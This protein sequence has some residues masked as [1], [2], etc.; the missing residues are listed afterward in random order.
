MPDNE[1]PKRLSKELQG[2]IG[3][4]EKGLEELRKLESK[5]RTTNSV[6]NYTKVGGAVATSVG[7]LGVCAGV[8]AAVCSFITMS[9]VPLIA[10]GSAA[11]VGGTITNVSVEYIRKSRN[12][13][14]IFGFIYF[15][16]SYNFNTIAMLFEILWNVDI[17]DV[18]I[19]FF[20]FLA[21]LL[22]TVNSNEAVP[23]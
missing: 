17:C 22:N 5:V 13:L 21:W 6:C 18:T 11:F 15:L 1:S 23:A 3:R 20:M 12:R 7:A 19:E 2:L 16:L 10:A 9:P 4:V 14:V 8:W